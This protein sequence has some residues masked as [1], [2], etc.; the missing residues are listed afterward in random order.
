MAEGSDS[1]QAHDINGN[2]IVVGSYVLYL[3]TGTAGKALEIKQEEDGIWVMMDTTGLYYNAEAL[4]VTDADTIKVK[5]EREGVKVD[6]AELAREQVME[7]VVDITQVT[8][9]G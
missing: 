9:G 8:G 7:R 3:S 1:I 6:K 4:V 2:P 5:I